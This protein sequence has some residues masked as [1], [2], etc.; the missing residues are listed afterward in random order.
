M[1]SGQLG[2]MVENVLGEQQPAAVLGGLQV[3]AEL[4]QEVCSVRVTGHLHHLRQKFV[5]SV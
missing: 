1:V 3:A 2:G 4:L 5:K